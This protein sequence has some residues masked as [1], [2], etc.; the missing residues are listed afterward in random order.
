MQHG[1]IEVCIRRVQMEYAAKGCAAN[2]L[3]LGAKKKD[4]NVTVCFPSALEVPE[5]P[6]SAI[7]TH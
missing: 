6:K 4:L 2:L 7:Q 1:R 3:I 5:S